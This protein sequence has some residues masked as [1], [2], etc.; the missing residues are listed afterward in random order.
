M[1]GT[2][3]V[4]HKINFLIMSCSYS[5]R[6]NIPALMSNFGDIAKFPATGNMT[7][8]GPVLFIGGGKSDYIQ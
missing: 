6:I 3:I 7:Y 5:W 4:F 2:F 1:G 8:S